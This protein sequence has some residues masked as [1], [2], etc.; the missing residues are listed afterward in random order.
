LYEDALGYFN[1]AIEIDS[2]L[3]KAQHGMSIC[4]RHL[5][6]HEEAIQTVSEA[7]ALVPHSQRLAVSDMQSDLTKMLL[8]KMDFTKVFEQTKNVYC[9]DP[10][11]PRAIGGHIQAMYALHDYDGIVQ[12]METLRKAEIK[13][14]DWANVSF[15]SLR[16]V[17]FEIGCALRT[18]NKLDLVKPWVD[19]CSST[20]DSRI[21]FSHSPWL[22]AVSKICLP[23]PANISFTLYFMSCVPLPPHAFHIGGFSPGSS[24][25]ILK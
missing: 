11:N 18:K 7:L 19:A 2:T 16:D 20:D 13:L 22:A 8:A 23:N 4:L 1:Q 12:M 6:R 14:E 10:M 25:L 15:I 9:S 24:Q 17:H 21:D 5:D 3:W